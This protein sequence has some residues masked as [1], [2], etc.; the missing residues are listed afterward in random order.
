MPARTSLRRASDSDYRAFYDK[1]PPADWVG[2]VA[3]QNGRLTAFAYVLIDPQARA[4]V[5][6]D[7]ARCVPPL[8]LH[9]MIRDVFAAMQQEGIPVLFALCDPRISA[10]GRW[11]ARLGF[12]V[13]ERHEGGALYTP[14]VYMP[15]VD[16]HLAVWKRILGDGMER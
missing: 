9:R 5:G 13:E 4:W 7:N 15:T 1:E 6:I 14:I 10:A 3:E 16:K 8:M 2:W 12:S 11:L